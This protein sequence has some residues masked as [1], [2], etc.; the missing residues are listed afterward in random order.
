M[1]NAGQT[2]E[3]VSMAINAVF[4]TSFATLRLLKFVFQGLRFLQR[5]TILNLAF[6]VRFLP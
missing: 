6:N 3:W 1:V 5:L 4:I 2:I